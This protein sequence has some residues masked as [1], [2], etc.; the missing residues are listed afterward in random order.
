MTLRR[1]NDVGLASFVA[2]LDS[3]KTDSPRGVPRQLLTAPESSEAVD[4]EIE[5]EARAFG[6]RL[7]AAGYLDERLS[8][9]KG[10]ERDRGL[11]AWLAL[12][13]FEQLC[14]PDKQGRRKPGELAR[15]IP[16]PTNYRRYYRHLLLGPFAIFR[17][18]HDNPERALVLLHGHPSKIDDLTG[19]LAAYQQI[20]SN[21]AIMEMATRLYIT[22]GKRSVRRGAGGKGPGSARRLV[23]IWRQFDVTW[24]MYAMD[25]DKLLDLMPREFSRFRN[26][27]STRQ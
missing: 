9:L 23:D 1:L 27:S 3:L 14:P 22:A 19:Q 12:F 17:A 26:A 25:A 4:G 5:I 24:D 21:K 6:S 7:E 13:Y 16:E 10:V 20:V 2:F 8:G 11:W 18:H 15:W